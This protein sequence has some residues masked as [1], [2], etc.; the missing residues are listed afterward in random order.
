MNSKIE[1]WAKESAQR[2]LE[3]EVRFMKPEQREKYLESVADLYLREL[4]EKSNIIKY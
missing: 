2:K 3:A 4:S 1:V